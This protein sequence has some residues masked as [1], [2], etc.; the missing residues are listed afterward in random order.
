M[1]VRVKDTEPNNSGEE[2]N[3]NNSEDKKEDGGLGMGIIIAIAVVGGL[4]V[5]TIIFIIF[6]LPRIRMRIQ[7]IY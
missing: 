5:F 7:V 2:D 3:E 4:A 1:L 6:I